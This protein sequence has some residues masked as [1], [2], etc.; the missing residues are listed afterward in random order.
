M[1]IAQPG[2]YLVMS[3]MLTFVL[4]F[5]STGMFTSKIPEERI[6]INLDHTMYLN[7]RYEGLGLEAVL[8]RLATA[9][10]S[11]GIAALKSQDRVSVD[12]TKGNNVHDKQKLDHAYFWD[13]VETFFKEDG[14]FAF[15]FLPLVESP[16]YCSLKTKQTSSFQTS[17][18][19]PWDSSM[20]RSPLEL[21]F[22][23]STSGALSD[24]QQALS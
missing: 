12:A 4:I 23:S 20:P 16:T 13:R 22:T 15:C 9:A 18:H 6:E 10:A 8:S 2:L 5:Y 19:A 11:S 1:R 17:E 21:S 14:E 7:K 3:S 24:G